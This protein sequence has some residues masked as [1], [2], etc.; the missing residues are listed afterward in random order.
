MS[1]QFD[2]PPMTAPTRTSGSSTATVIIVVLASLFFVA[3]LCGGVL[4]A[5]LL[6]AVQQA[7]EAARRMQCQNNMRQI[8]LALMNYEQ[9]YGQFPPAFTVDAQGNRLHSWRTLILPFMEQQALASQI[10]MTKPWNAPEN[11]VL[12]TLIPAY[13]CPST[14][15]DLT[16]YTVVIHPNGIFTGS[17]PGTKLREVTDGASNTLLVVESGKRVP[18][19]SPE[20]VSI[21]EYVTSL[22]DVPHP[23][24]ANAVFCDA[25]V[26]FMSEQV[27]PT[28]LEAMVT[29]D[30]GEIVA[31]P[32]Y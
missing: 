2:Q 28:D 22:R 17:G 19:A 30:Q 12:E 16:P 13:Q 11:A 14:P 32:G 8:S 15:G 20:D 5:L 3:L 10:D 4:V 26:Q 21:D 24:G 6:P 18:W 27:S 31:P 1:N 29:K 25:S 7:R 9:T 23:G